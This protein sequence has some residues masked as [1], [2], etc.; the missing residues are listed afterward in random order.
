MRAHRSLTP[1]AT[2]TLLRATD[3]MAHGIVVNSRAVMRELELEDRVA[4]SRMRL[5]YNGLDTSIFRPDG[6]RAT[7]PW[8]DATVVIGIAC[9]LRPE[10]GLD[11]LID[12]FRRVKAGHPG[13]KLL[14]VGSGP[15][16]TELQAAA[17]EDVH[18]EPAQ[19]N[20]APWL[21]AM[22]I[23]VLPSLSEA[24]SNSLME[25]MGCGCCPVAS[26]TGGNP[27]LVQDGET[28]LLFPVGDAGALA[29]RLARLLDDAGLRRGLAEAAACRM[30]EEF[31]R[32]VAAR[33]M[34]A[35]YEEF[36]GKAGKNPKS[37]EPRMNTD[38]HG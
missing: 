11:L 14:I 3:R 8:S 29:D 7:L 17:G 31:N 9:A 6:E 16:L 24:L 13:V 26:D 30:K 22:D 1:G 36:L 35:I 18:F 21:R 23:F 25:A 12:A 28:G 15:M 4:P 37:S 38:T 2:R 10:K 27:E 5:V 32:E 34:G 19:R 33:R 20:V